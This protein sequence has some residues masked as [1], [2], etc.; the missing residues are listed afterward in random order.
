MDIDVLIKRYNDKG[1]SVKA[2][3]D[4]VI[5]FIKDFKKRAD[6]EVEEYTREF[7]KNH[8]EAEISLMETGEIK[9]QSQDF[10]IFEILDDVSQEWFG[11][12]E[13]AKLN[14]KD[15]GLFDLSLS[16][17]NPKYY[18]SWKNHQRQRLDITFQ[19]PFE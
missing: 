2:L 13:K 1:R 14:S 11:F 9:V 18:K 8:S 4:I 17:L 19:S 10:K 3:V 12:A 15:A 6:A 5:D 16:E 7:E